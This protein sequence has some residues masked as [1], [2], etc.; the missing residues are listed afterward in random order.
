M[1]T[2]RLKK[3]QLLNLFEFSVDLIGEKIHADFT[4]KVFQS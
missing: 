1:N 4:I 2:E 3:R